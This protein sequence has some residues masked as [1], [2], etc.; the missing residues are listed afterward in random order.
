M[1]RMDSNKNILLTPTPDFLVGDCGSSSTAR[2]VRYD[3]NLH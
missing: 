2:D 1:K 3:V